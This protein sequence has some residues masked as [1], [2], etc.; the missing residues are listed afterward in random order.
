MDMKAAGKQING[1]KLQPP[2]QWR[3]HSQ[4]QSV[5]REYDLKESFLLGIS[6]KMD[7]LAFA[8]KHFYKLALCNQVNES[9]N[10][11]PHE[12]ATPLILELNHLR[13]NHSSLIK[14]KEDAHKALES[15]LSSH[16]ELKQ[17]VE[18]QSTVND[19]LQLHIEELKAKKT[20]LLSNKSALGES[21]GRCQPRW[22]LLNSSCY[23]FSNKNTDS[24]KNW[25]ESRADCISRGG[26]LLVIDDWDEQRLITDNYR[27]VRSSDVWWANGYWIGLTDI[28][29][30]GTWVWINGVIQQEPL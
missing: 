12:I 27:D 23:F 10:Q 11:I 13:S 22:T 3:I 19:G 5:D 7:I 6:A 21:C 24:Q 25:P 16:M 28:E 26:D 4:V 17:Q 1:Y 29:K 14:A 20:Y 15:E 2:V 30:E 18:R 9:Y 8:S